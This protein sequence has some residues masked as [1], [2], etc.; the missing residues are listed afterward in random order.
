VLGVPIR[1]QTCHARILYWQRIPT[2][3]CRPAQQRLEADAA[4][5]IGGVPPLAD[6][7]RLITIAAWMHG[8]RRDLGKVHRSS[9]L[10]SSCS[11]A[12]LACSP[13]LA[14][15]RCS[16]RRIQHLHRRRRSQRHSGRSLKSQCDQRTDRSHRASIPSND[17]SHHSFASRSQRRTSSAS[18]PSPRTRSEDLCAADVCGRWLVCPT[19]PGLIDRKSR[20]LINV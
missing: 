16:S 2:R 5:V 10:Y 15:S 14:H 6:S 18:P 7:S 4:G 19:A 13:A 1:Y 20:E 9:Q 8:G 3:R 11:A 12:A 17:A